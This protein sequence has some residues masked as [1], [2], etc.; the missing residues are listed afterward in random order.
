MTQEDQAL[1]IPSQLL[2]PRAAMG[3][4]AGGWQPG[5]TQAAKHS[6]GLAGQVGSNEESE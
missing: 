4:V 5:F 3:Q 6:W 1:D 2:F